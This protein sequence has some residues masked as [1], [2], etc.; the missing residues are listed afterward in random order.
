MRKRNFPSWFHDSLKE[1]ALERLAR[2]DGCSLRFRGNRCVL[3]RI[4]RCVDSALAPTKKCDFAVVSENATCLVE[5]VCGRARPRDAEEAIEKFE[6]T[7]GVLRKRGAIKG[8]CERVLYTMSLTSTLAQNLRLYTGRLGGK[9]L[10]G[11][12]GELRILSGKAF[13]LPVG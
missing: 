6:A 12:H 9:V 13:L 7:E 1:C 2:D 10:Q 3:V 4:D 11:H 8:K 5:F